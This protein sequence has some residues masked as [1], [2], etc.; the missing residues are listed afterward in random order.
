VA[1]KYSSKRAL[2]RSQIEA[3]G[4]VAAEWSILEFELMLA[5]GVI[6][7]MTSIE[8]AIALGGAL[9]GANT[10]GLAITRAANVW[11][12]QSDIASNVEDLMDDISELGTMRNSVIHGMWAI[13]ATKDASG[14]MRA[15]AHGLCSNHG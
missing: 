12:D 4:F 14:Q 2:T 7:K 5:L 11:K 1:S 10:I 8:P 9:G 13:P 3:I 15:S 6:L